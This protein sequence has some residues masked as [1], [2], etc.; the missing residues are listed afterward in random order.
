MTVHPSVRLSARLSRSGT[1]PK[2]F[3]ISAQGSPIILCCAVLIIYANFDGVIPTGALN[4][5]WVYK[6]RDFLRRQFAKFMLADSL[7]VSHNISSPVNNSPLKIYY[8]YS[9][10]CAQQPSFLLLLIIIIISFLLYFVVLSSAI[11]RI[12]LY[13]PIYLFTYII[14]TRHIP[15]SLC[16]TGL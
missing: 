14:L 9:C 5:S 2:R 1:V 3:N 6:F 10:Q 7:A 4:T 12:K 11:W 8:C 13:R 16:A 15:C